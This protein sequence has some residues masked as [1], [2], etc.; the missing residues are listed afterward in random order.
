[1]FVAVV[2]R[3]ANEREEFKALDQIPFFMHLKR[4]HEQKLK[5]FNLLVECCYKQKNQF[6]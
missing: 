1:M 4:L 2:N 6:Q 5:E 3:K